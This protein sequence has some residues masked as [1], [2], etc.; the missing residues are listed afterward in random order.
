MTVQSRWLFRAAA[1][2]AIG[3]VA[4]IA[5]AWLAAAFLDAHDGKLHNLQYEN[6]VA[7]PA[8]VGAPQ[9][10]HLRTWHE[11]RGPGIRY[12]LISECEWMG[13]KLG[14][15]PATA[16]NRTLQRITTGWPLPAMQYDS[17]PAASA[18]AGG[19]PIAGS[20]KIGGLV[21]RRLP[22]RPL[23]VPFLTD[24]ATFALAGFAVLI[25]ES[26]IRTARRRR[27]GQCPACGYPSAGLPRCPECG[28]PTSPA[29]GLQP[30]EPS[31]AHPPASAP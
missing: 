25:S 4:T 22:I 27:R 9:D 23:I 19:L 24:A 29:Q 12:D 1:S 21:A 6:G 2:I 31:P 28:A 16:P 15:S 11:L 20:S 10:W 14:S 3:V 30:P 8:Y 7:I 18:W 26:A 17:N 5:S 13:S